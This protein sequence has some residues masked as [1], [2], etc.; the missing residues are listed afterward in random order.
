MPAHWCFVFYII[1]LGIPISDRQRRSDR[2]TNYLNV[3][4]ENRK[5][6]S[7]KLGQNV[8]IN[9]LMMCGNISKKKYILR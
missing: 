1:N 6:G 2:L 5:S 9:Q 7:L 8:R 4:H 3:L